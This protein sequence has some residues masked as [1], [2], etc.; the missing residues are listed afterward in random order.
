MHIYAYV[1]FIIYMTPV[2]MII[3]FSFQKWE[4]VKNKVLSFDGMTLANY[5]GKESAFIPRTGKR[6]AGKFTE[7]KD[8][9]VGLF[10][11]DKTTDSIVLSFIL[12]AIAAAAVCVIVVLAVNYMFKHKKARSS[13]AVEAGMLFPWLLP[14]ILICYSYRIY[15]KQ[16]LWYTFGESLSSPDRIRLLLI[17][18]YVVV[19]LPFTLRMIKASFYAIDEEL[20]EAARNLGSGPIR[21]FMRIKLPI[22]LPSV[23]AVFAL[24]FN[25]LFSEYD[26]GATF[27]NSRATTLAMVVKAL[28]DE[29][30]NALQINQEGCRCAAT[31]L[32]M[33]VSTVIL[34]LVYGVGSRDLAERLD[35][36]ARRRA[37]FA[38]LTGRSRRAK[39]EAA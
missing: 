4:N 13:K 21:S 32:I 7:L 23:L 39:K 27:H 34:Y 28:T 20:E 25:A 22:V 18:A 26:M 5:I 31:V 17:V 3:V 9:V 1:L 37:R 29:G 2:V 6:N 14:T 16:G 24:N 15:F 19:K 33:V 38:R 10:S 11:Y 36:R 8:A 35:R 30:N 12:S